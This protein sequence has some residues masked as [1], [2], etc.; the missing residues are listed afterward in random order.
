MH[1][2]R[3]LNQLFLKLYILAKKNFDVIFY[4]PKLIV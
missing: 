4:K 3:L 1:M 2:S